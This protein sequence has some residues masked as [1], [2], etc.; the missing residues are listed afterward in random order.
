MNAFRTLSLFV[1]LLLASCDRKE[2]ASSP[3]TP[4]TRAYQLEYLQPNETL[5]ALQSLNLDPSVTIR[6]DN[7]ANRIVATYKRAED[8]EAIADL[9]E[10]I[11]IPHVSPPTR[12]IELQ[13]IDAETAVQ[14]VSARF[15][16]TNPTFNI[17]PDIRTNRVF[18]TGT[19]EQIEKV[20]TMLAELDVQEAR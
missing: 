12:F 8:G 11:D 6:A 20:S 14:T 1:L 4:L 15:P 13:F 5:R 2:A 9:L 19:T 7:D 10:Q 18:L 3:S 16:Q 17:I